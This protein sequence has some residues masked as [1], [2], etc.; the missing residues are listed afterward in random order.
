MNTTIDS[1]GPNFLQVDRVP[2]RMVGVKA[3]NLTSLLDSVWGM[4]MG[5]RGNDKGGPDSLQFEYKVPRIPKAR[6]KKY[7]SSWNQIRAVARQQCQNR[8]NH[9]KYE[10]LNNPNGMPYDSF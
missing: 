5:L 3:S 2:Q 7:W 10:A 9:Q 6:L 4:V 8:E 1:Q